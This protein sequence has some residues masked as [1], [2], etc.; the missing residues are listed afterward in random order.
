M[1]CLGPRRQIHG[2]ESREDSSWAVARLG[3]GPWRLCQEAWPVPASALLRISTRLP[4]AP[5]S[6]LWRPQRPWG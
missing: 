1:C 2:G 3:L 6:S 5:P 4:K